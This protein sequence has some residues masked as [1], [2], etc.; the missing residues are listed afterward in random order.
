MR[1]KI[2]INRKKYKM[3]IHYEKLCVLGGNKGRQGKVFKVQDKESRF[4]FALKQV[5]V[6]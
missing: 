2:V 6:F 3:G 4:I 1:K 5:R